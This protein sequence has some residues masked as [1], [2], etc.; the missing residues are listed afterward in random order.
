[1]D[2]AQVYRDYE[3]YV[4]LCTIVHMED[5]ATG[6]RLRRMAPKRGNLAYANKL[7]KRMQGLEDGLDELQWDFPMPGRIH[8]KCF[9]F[10]VTLTYDQKAT[11]IDEAWKEI[12]NDIAK[13]KVELKRAFHADHINVLTVK[14]GTASGYPAPHML[15]IVDKPITCVRHRNKKGEVTFRLADMGQLHHVKSAWKRGFLDIKAVVSNRI[16]SKSAIHYVMKYLVKAV[17]IE[18]HDIAFKQMAWQKQY[19]LR[20]MHISQSF[21]NL[22]NPV[23]LETYCNE[24]QQRKSHYWVYEGSESCALSDFQRIMLQK[25]Q[26]LVVPPPEPEWITERKALLRCPKDIEE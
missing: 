9:M 25:V 3:D 11:P 6:D 1:M 8:R 7:K 16:E 19:N 10:L 18:Q 20:A 13:S 23:R 12:S 14:E 17:D 5:L 2:I 15:V 21:K 26:P 22:S 4:N 24:S